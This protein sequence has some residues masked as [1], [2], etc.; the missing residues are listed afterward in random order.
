MPAV[1]SVAVLAEKIISR[2]CLCLFS[3]EASV[4]VEGNIEVVK[5]GGDK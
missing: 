5:H 2:C 3:V 1:L 4:G